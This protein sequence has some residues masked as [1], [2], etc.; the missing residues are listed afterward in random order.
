MDDEE[1]KGKF[2]LSMEFRNKVVRL[3][4]RVKHDFIFGTCRCE[5][6]MCADVDSK[7]VP[8]CE[9]VLLSF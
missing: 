2:L 1:E 3:S 9:F 5:F 8:Q 4:H 6:S 7:A